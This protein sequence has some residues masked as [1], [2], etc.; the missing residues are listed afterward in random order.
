MK[1]VLKI[2]SSVLALVILFAALP[3]TASAE[4]PYELRIE[5]EY[6]P[7]LTDSIKVVSNSYGVWYAFLPST[8]SAETV[9]ITASDELFEASG[10]GLISAD[11][12]AGIVVCRAYNGAMIS[13]DGI[14]LVVMK[15]C[16]PAMN[17]S[18]DPDEDLSLIHEFRDF[19]I[20]VTVGISGTDNAEYDLAPAKAQMKTRGY[21]TFRY[22]KKPYQIK[23]DKK[24]DLFGMGK[25]KKWILLANYLD[26]T[27]VR[28]KLI[29]D[30][31]TEI[32]CGYTPESVFV[33]LYIDG[34]YRGVY[35]LTEKVE[36]GSSRV[37]LKDEYGVLI[38]LDMIDRLDK[39]EDI[40]FETS[41]GKGAVFKDSVAD[42]EELIKKGR[43]DKVNEIVDFYSKYFER[44]EDLLYGE[45][46]TWDQIESM[47]DVD[48][49]ARFY[50]I[51]EFSEEV[52][53]TFASTFFYMDGKDDVLHCGPLW[54]YDRCFGLSI[55]Y[56]HDTRADFFKNITVSTDDLRVE[57]FKQLFRYDE[58]ATRVNDIYDECAR[59]AFDANKLDERIWAYQGAMEASLMM[60]YALWPV[61]GSVDVTG[62]NYVDYYYDQMF[63]LWEVTGEMTYWI[64]GR[65][66]F[67]ESAYRK[68]IPILRYSTLE[69][70]GGETAEYTS[71]CLTDPAAVSGLK[72]RIVNGRDVPDGDVEYWVIYE[73]EEYGPSKN[74]T[75]AESSDGRVTGIR[76]R[77]TGN[78]ANYFSL[79][80]R[81]L[82]NNN[83]LTGWSRDGAFAGSESGIYK[84]CG[85]K[86]VEFRLLRKKPLEYSTMTADCFAVSTE[87]TGIVGD[88]VKPETPRVRGFRFEGWYDN[89]DLSGDPVTDP[90][91]GEVSA[92]YA[93]MTEKTIVPGDANCDGRVDMKDVLS[94][95]KAIL[96]IIGHSDID[97]DNA[98]M[99]GNGIMEMRD[100]LAI[101]K[102]ILRIN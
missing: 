77:L 44:F 81:I 47:I 58:F 34:E 46:T 25:A 54:D 8:F 40:Y 68:D 29:F 86:S 98:D 93:K 63:S 84:S 19:S 100:V 61:C 14:D 13:I 94:V 83:E 75:K 3:L 66:E 76:A 80:Y 88:A 99:N 31:G 52:D 79:E 71:G 64:S 70:G 87:Y 91:F 22:D 12:D 56:E 28:N 90:V 39:F 92:L 35:Q 16:L 15:G 78:A 30:L 26:G 85:V 49:F 36:I 48:S 32:G 65:S 21:S 6:N 18:V 41:T 7:G 53:A 67:M 101:R 11:L 27:A 59:A 42:L 9:T 23:F 10:Y 37:D 45:S 57:W 51:T 60:N 69:R 38:E 33:D 95:R 97:E 89:A 82:Q 50:L 20:D 24:T 2:A 55:N 43:Y 74:G 17:V 73:S 1:T 62:E 96:G 5:P 4:D 102:I 72:L